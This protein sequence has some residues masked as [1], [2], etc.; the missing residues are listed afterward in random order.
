[1]TTHNSSVIVAT[2]GGGSGGTVNRQ[3]SN[4]NISIGTYWQSHTAPSLTVK[5]SNNQPDFSIHNDGRLEYQ[6]QFIKI[7]DLFI[8]VNLIKKL[9]FDVATN[10]ELSEKLPYLKDA[11]HDW[12]INDLKK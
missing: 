5:G 3:S 10:P 4:S 6:G 11:A 8:A 2:G 7:Q 9:A 1:M 12:V